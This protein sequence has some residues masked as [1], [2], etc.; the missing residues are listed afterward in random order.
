MKRNLGT[1]ILSVVML[2]QLN[3]CTNLDEEVFSEIVADNFYNNKLEVTAAVLRPYTH[4]GASL[5]SWGGQRNYWRLNELSA[6]QLALPQKGTHWYNGGEFIRLHYHNWTPDESNI[7]NPWDLLYRGVGFCNNV[8]A[9]LDGVDAEQV[10]MTTEELDAAKAEV[11]V[12]R[13]FCHMKLMDLYGDVPVITSVGSPLNPSRV[14]RSKVFDFVEAEIRESIDM[15]PPLSQSIVG[16]MSKAGAYAILSELYLNAETWTGTQRWDDCIAASN[17]ILSGQVGG[18]NGTA[19]LEADITSVFST[20]NHESNEVLLSIAY[21]YLATNYWYKWNNDL[22]HYNQKQ[23]YNANQG[24]NNG[25]VVTPTA[26]DAFQE[27][28]LRKHTWMLIG[29]QYQLGTDIPI[30]G[31]QEYNGKPLVFVREIQRNS[32]GKTQ[33]DMTQGEENSGARFA[34]YV[35]GQF[36]DLD[37]W[38]NDLVLYRLT[39]IYFN[40]AEA[41]MRKNGGIATDDA[42]QL[43]N[44]CRKRAFKEEDWEQ[45]LYTR[46][47]LTLDELLAERG[48]EFIF[49]GKRRTD[50]IRFDKFTTTSWWDHKPT[51]STK[52]VFPIP[53]S[54]LAAN[55]NLTQNE[56]Y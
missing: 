54:Q 14:S 56:G 52:R 26:Y 12:M 51:S 37:Y 7:Q 27:N 22:W 36:T 42:I 47:S 30:L 2:S 49:E 38:S 33:S 23:I 40:K 21:D 8:L 19:A 24:G 45:A 34:K 3:A 5:S 29:P 6:D 20:D 41:L 10:G 46:S 18:Q 35:P 50:L 1:Y 43:I 15:L 9:E 55:P 32:E 17:V 11:R 16:R 31:T 4:I 44:E 25:I 48:R 53:S 39:E 13:A 28:D